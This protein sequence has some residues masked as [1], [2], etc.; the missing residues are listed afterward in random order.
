MPDGSAPQ[1]ADDLDLLSALLVSEVPSRQG[2]LH[3][4]RMRSTTQQ[5]QIALRGFQL[6]N[7]I[8]QALHLAE[9]SFVLA[10]VVAFG[11]VTRDV[12]A[13]S[14][15]TIRTQTQVSASCN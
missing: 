12:F 1:G 2:Q 3:P 13:E 14:C 8:D 10:A 15:A 11:S 4:A 5:Q 9:R 7:W 6:R